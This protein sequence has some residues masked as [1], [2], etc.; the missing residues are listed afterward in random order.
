MKTRIIQN[1]PSEPAGRRVESATDASPPRGGSRIAFTVVGSIVAVLAVVALAAGGAVVVVHQT[2]RDGD[3]FY[4]SDAKTL[5]T[6]THALVSDELDVGTDTPDWLF[7]K[8][9]LGTVRVTATG[10][11]AKPIFVGVARTS[12]LDAYLRGVARDEITD[13]ELRP[14]SVT[15]THRP[16]T[17]TPSAP[18]SQSFWAASAAGTGRQTATWTV[19]EGS[20]GVVVMNADGAAG[21]VTD[22]SVGAKAGVLLWLGIGLLVA[23]AIAGAGAGALIVLGVRTGPASPGRSASTA[24]A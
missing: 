23:G 15:S 1:D 16:G 3:G 10:T 14:F 21:V 4:A 18:T 8:G 24:T 22:V 5:T 12:Q 13:F 20:W 19:R 2:Q 6:P 17:A 9:R 7:R 11:A